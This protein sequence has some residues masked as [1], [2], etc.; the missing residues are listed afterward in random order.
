MRIPALIATLAFLFVSP[1][2][3]GAEE[4]W[5]KVQT[6]HF[7]VL[8]NGSV[9]DARDVATNFEQIHAVFAQVFPNLRTDASAQ[10]IVLAVKDEKTFVELLAAERRLLRI[11][12]ASC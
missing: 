8:S 7:L 9:K 2:L 6:P 1:R 4:S 11:L 10:T 12:A 3:Y 5:V